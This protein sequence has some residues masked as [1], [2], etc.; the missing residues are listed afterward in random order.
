MNFSRA[1]HKSQVKNIGDEDVIEAIARV[2]WYTIEF[3]LVKEGFM[4]KIYGA[5]I[6]SSI[7]ETNY[8][9]SYKARRIPFDLYTVLKTPYIK[10]RFQE[11]YFVLSSMQQLK[12]I[13]SELEK[14]FENNN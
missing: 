13:L 14:R 12:S 9:Q 3:G 11:Q 2:Y 6:L 8:C 5:G 10:D 4:Y 7:S 1:S